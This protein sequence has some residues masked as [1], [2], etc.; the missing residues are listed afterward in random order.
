MLNWAVIPHS[1]T[2]LK[3]VMPYGNIPLATHRALIDTVK[4]TDTFM[5]LI[6]E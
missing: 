1:T 2:I 6:F 3:W 5:R 4:Y